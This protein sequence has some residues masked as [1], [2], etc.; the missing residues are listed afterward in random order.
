M[1]LQD[2]LDEDKKSFL[3]KAPPEPSEIV[4][5]LQSLV[6]GVL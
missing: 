4:K 3:E 6:K 2:K 5:E 1:G